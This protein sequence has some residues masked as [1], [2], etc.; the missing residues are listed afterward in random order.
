M[1]PTSDAK[2]E[3]MTVPKHKPGSRIDW[4]NAGP[5]QIKDEIAR[6]RA[7]MDEHLSQLGR[8]FQPGAK[9]KRVGIPI[10]AAMAMAVSGLMVFRGFRRHGRRGR[11]A[12]A[13]VE[14]LKIKS[15]G[16]WDQVRAV[17]LAL[18]LARKGKPAIFIVEPRRS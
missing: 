4:F 11:G 5:D 3:T 14:R 10:A 6:T 18:N 13:K 16:M 12:A 9:F 8:K 17:R 1:K 7:H 15:A 2:P